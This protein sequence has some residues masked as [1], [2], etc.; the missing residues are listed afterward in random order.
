MNEWTD[1]QL[2]EDIRRLRGEIVNLDGV[3]HYDHEYND[4]L[5]DIVVPR[6]MQRTGLTYDHPLLLD[7]DRRWEYKRLADMM[8]FFPRPVGMTDA[9][10]RLQ[11]LV[12]YEEALISRYLS[13]YTRNG[14]PTG[15]LLEAVEENAQ[16]TSTFPSKSLNFDAHIKRAAGYDEETWLAVLGFHPI[17]LPKRIVQFKGIGT[18][19][20]TSKTMNQLE[21]RMLKT[22]A[23]Q[24]TEGIV[25]ER[26][27]KEHNDMVQGALDFVQILDRSL[28]STTFF[29]WRNDRMKPRTYVTEPG[30]KT[31]LDAAL[32]KIEDR[33]KG[34]L[35]DPDFIRMR[36][37]LTN[38]TRS[39]PAFMNQTRDM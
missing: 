14:E 17:D 5:H 36:D 22:W 15:V 3:D 13:H 10:N 16:E 35:D 28:K 21:N 27:E 18:D 8:T 39:F 11:V 24:K 38:L 2:D 32:N 33:R 29:N 20:H 7:H 34:T 31:R 6:E 26:L 12:D 4:F 9:H 23:I 30:E 25:Q 1:A 19:N 37:R